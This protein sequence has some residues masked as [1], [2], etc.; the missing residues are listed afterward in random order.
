MLV[1][2]DWNLPHTRVLATFQRAKLN[3]GDIASAL[4]ILYSSSEHTGRRL[5][6]RSFTVISVLEEITSMI[7]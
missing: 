5:N 1:I 2:I 4:S 7:A 3:Y 6:I